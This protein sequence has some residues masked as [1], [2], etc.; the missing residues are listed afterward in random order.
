MR[1]NTN[2]HHQRRAFTAALGGLVVERTNEKEAAKGSGLV[3]LP[4]KR[5][6]TIPQKA[7]KIKLLPPY[8]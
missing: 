5:R 4:L 2:D 7:A 8:G 1:S 3:E 6:Q